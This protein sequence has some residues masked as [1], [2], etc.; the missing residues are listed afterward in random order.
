VSSFGPKSNYGRGPSRNVRVSSTADT[1]ITV[2]NRWF[3]RPSYL[4]IF[5][6]SLSMR[7]YAHEID[8]RSALHDLTLLGNCDRHK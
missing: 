6:C 2:L 4:N 5:C 8:R 7:S 3:K 1:A